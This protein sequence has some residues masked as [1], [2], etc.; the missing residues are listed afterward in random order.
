MAKIKCPTHGV[1]FEAIEGC[2]Q[3]VAERKEA[4]T[5]PEY[6][7]TNIIKVIYAE[8]SKEYS[9]YSEDRLKVG[10]IVMVQV[11]DRQTNA[12]VTEIDVPESEVEAFKDKVKTIPADSVIPP[13]AEV[14]SPENIKKRID[15]VQPKLEVGEPIE[16]TESSLAEGRARRAIPRDGRHGHGEG[17]PWRHAIICQA[18]SSR[19][20]HR[21]DC[22]FTANPD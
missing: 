3:C 9:Y 15:A 21:G 7:T 8:G 17:R 18:P 16:I 19:E 10:D 4:E 6:H 14:N 12:T 1:D 13:E 5:K 2:P 20:A 22:I 11:R